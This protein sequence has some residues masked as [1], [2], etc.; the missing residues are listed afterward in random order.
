MSWSQSLLLQSLG[1]ATLNSFWQMG[2]LWCVYS[3][4]IRY[5]TI[6]SSRKYLFASSSVFLGTAWFAYTFFHYLMLGKESLPLLQVTINHRT[7]LLPLVLSSASIT[8]LLLLIVPCYK[9]FRNWRFVRVI[10]RTGTQK[11]PARYRVFVKKIGAHIGI[12]K[13][14]IVHLS[15][16]VTSPMTI[17][18]LKPLILVPIAALNN[19]TPAQMEAVLLHELSHIRRSDYMVN[20]MLACAQLLLYFNPFIRLFIKAVEAE[21]ENC[22]DE[23]VLQFEYDKISYASALLQLEKHNHETAAV[24]AMTATNKT[25]LLS[26]IEKIVGMQKKTKLNA[27]HLF[28]AFAALVLLLTLNSLIITTKGHLKSA[29]AFNSFSQPYS[30]FVNDNGGAHSPAAVAVVKGTTNT[31]PV[32]SVASPA[33]HQNKTVLSTKNNIIVTDY[34][35]LPAIPEPEKQPQFLNVAYDMTDADLTQEQKDQV[36]STVE[37]TRKVLEGQWIEVEKAVPDGL[38]PREKAS[39]KR[40][41]LSEVNKVNWKQME[42]S[43]KARYDNINWPKVD[44]NLTH[45]LTRIKLDSLRLSY[46]I[47]LTALQNVNCSKAKISATPI[48]DV[49]VKDLQIAKKELQ[50]KLTELKAIRVK[51]IVKL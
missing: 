9:L 41:Y 14:V 36:K 31:T 42:Q 37:N 16:L 11:A 34:S 12:R 19:L 1:W 46:Q 38:T 8:Y 27:Q 48:P 26:R 20:M 32:A 50:S 10:R 49:S 23:L 3:L 15:S 40:E 25:H 29:D 45:Q 4:V 6:S 39:V 51:K 35:E 13:P 22:C 33:V 2:L 24:L 44:N 18:F 43:M 28:G 47:A 7:D 30:F 21:R 17:G 5:T